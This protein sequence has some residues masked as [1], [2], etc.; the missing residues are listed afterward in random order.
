M[1]KHIFY[2][3]NIY[4]YMYIYVI[5]LLHFNYGQYRQQLF[6]MGL[7]QLSAL[8]PHAGMHTC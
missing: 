4:N 5:L 7:Q 2:M 8:Y 6:R 1:A 3:D